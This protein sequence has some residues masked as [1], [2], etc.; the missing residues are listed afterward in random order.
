MPQLQ[1][2]SVFIRLLEREQP[3]LLDGGLATQLESQGCDISNDLWSASLLQSDPDAIFAAHHAY[4]SAGAECL[5][6][7]SY[8]ASRAGF[9][10]RG[11]SDDEADALMLLSVALAK[12]AR[13]EAASGVAVA[14]SL[15]PY[16]ATLHDG[17]EYV[18]NYG[19]SSAALRK[20]HEER[21]QLFD[22][23]GADVL[24]LET[25]PSY[26]EAEVLC[27]LLRDCKTPAWVSFSCRDGTHISDGTLLSDA[28]ALFVEHP[29]VIAVGINCTPPQ[30]APSLIRE[31]RKSLSDKHILAYP[32]SG[33][34]YD[35]KTNS[36]SGTV[37]PGDC[38]SAASEW[39]AA[40]AKIVGGCCR[41]GPSHIQAMAEMINA[42]RR[43]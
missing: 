12:R 11:M 34:V 18:G 33:E 36:W 5:A 31:V 3:L 26:Q 35:A 4:L 42:S 14:A 13:K 15:G 6:T 32:N 30:Y 39:I 1:S 24:A 16:G 10:R 41:M 37:T 8:Q 9:G 21:L 17:S 27:D 20:F 25:I 40:G 38:A 29:S 23:A 7:A 28:A 22:D 43:R 19:I 2:T